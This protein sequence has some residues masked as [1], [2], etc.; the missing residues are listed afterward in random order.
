MYICYKD[1]NFSVIAMNIIKEI[2]INQ[3]TLKQSNYLEL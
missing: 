3:L 2:K 1:F